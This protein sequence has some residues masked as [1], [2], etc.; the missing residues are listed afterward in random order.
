MTEELTVDDL[1]NTGITPIPSFEPNP[2]EILEIFD[3]REPLPE[4]V[5]NG[6]PLAPWCFDPLTNIY[7]EKGPCYLWLRFVPGW[8]ELELE[9]YD[10][11][12]LG[13]KPKWLREQISESGVGG[14]LDLPWHGTMGWMIGH[15]LSPGQPF[16]IEVYPPVWSKSG[17]YEVEYD[18]EWYWE[19]VRILPRT[20]KAAAS[21]WDRHIT[22]VRRGEEREKHLREV[23]EAKVR[24]KRI[25]DRAALYFRWESFWA[26]RYWDDMSPPDGIRV[27]L[28]SEHTADERGRHWLSHVIFEGESRTGDR[29]EAMRKLVEKAHRAGLVV[30]V[31]L[32]RIRKPWQ[33]SLPISEAEFRKLPSRW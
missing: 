10:D 23:G 18:C 21:S 27:Q 26:T 7:R 32:E 8:P 19:I 11:K 29:E 16:C 1:L 15:G 33:G 9:E 22:R 24:K 30:R 12:Q 14:I 17:Y 31:A 5:Q 28:C 13:S 2:D 20:P 3:E 25:G 6:E 4:E